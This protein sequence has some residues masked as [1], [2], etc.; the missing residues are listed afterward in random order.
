VTFFSFA[1]AHP[2]LGT[3]YLVIVASASLGT[4]RALA[5]AVVATFFSMRAAAK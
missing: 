5:S 1:D 2:I 3:V 4:A